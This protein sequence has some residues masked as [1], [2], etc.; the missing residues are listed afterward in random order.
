MMPTTPSST[1]SILSLGEANELD[2]VVLAATWIALAEWL[3]DSPGHCLVRFDRK[4]VAVDRGV[5]HAPLF[6]ECPEYGG[7]PVITRISLVL[8]RLRRLHL[9]A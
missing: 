7:L 2:V 8:D 6:F 4:L 5:I 3:S 1:A 9:C